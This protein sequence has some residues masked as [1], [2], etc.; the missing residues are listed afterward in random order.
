MFK[1]SSR[2]WLYAPISLFLIL[3]AIVMIHWW[4][5]AGAFEKKLAMLKGHEAV[6][7]ITLDWKTVAVSGFPFR[8]DADF[9][10]FRIHGAGAHGP[11][12]WSSE[13]FA[14]HGLTYGRSQNVYEAAGQQTLNWTGANG[15]AH[16]AAFLPGSMRGSSILDAQGL[17]RFDLEIV[18]LAG[19]DFTIRRLQIHLRRDPDGGDLD[20]MLKA[21]ALQTHTLKAEKLQLYTTLNRAQSL[22]ALLRG[23]APWPQAV[24]DWRAQ[25]G[26]AKPSQVIAPSA[27]A[28]LSPLY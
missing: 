25:G 24:F 15:A 8:L 11:F 1:Y 23:E 10:D 6:P 12:A 22:M 27:D 7:G 2:F 28:I 5:A 21:D 20:L 14:L 18:D 26:K 19:Q 9:T 17:R 13:K 4:L 3:A 16:A